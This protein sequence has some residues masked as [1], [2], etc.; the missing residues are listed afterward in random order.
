MFE[1]KCQ[2]CH[3]TFGYGGKESNVVTVSRTKP[4]Y[5]CIGRENFGCK[6]G[7]CNDCFW[8]KATLNDGVGGNKRSR[9][10][11]QGFS[12]IEI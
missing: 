4:A 3:A 8:T 11:N 9:R 1:S 2:L 5:F 12:I 10:K 7:Y 6:H